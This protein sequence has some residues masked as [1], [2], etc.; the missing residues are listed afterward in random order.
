MLR[1]TNDN[2]I[3]IED[4]NLP[5]VER[6][7]GRAREAKGGELLET[8]VEEGLDQLVTFP[9]HTKGN[10]LDLLLTNCSDKILDVSDVGRLGR[11]DHCMIK[12]DIDFH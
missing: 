10:I 7:R 9:T 5:G 2:T 12:V 8:A 1:A 3:F 11:C 6:E 4:F